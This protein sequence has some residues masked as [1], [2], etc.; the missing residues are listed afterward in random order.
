M[1]GTGRRPVAG[2]PRSL[3]VSAGFDTDETAT[4]RSTDDG[5]CD[6]PDD[7]PSHGDARNE[8]CHEFFLPATRSVLTLVGARDWTLEHGRP[9]AVPDRRRRA[10]R[11]E[12]LGECPPGRGVRA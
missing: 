4:P 9:S 12:W 11:R 8:Q 3:V 2:S 10:D 6:S 1:E 5:P 7:S